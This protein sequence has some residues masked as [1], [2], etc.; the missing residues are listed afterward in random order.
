M[1]EQ[2]KNDTLPENAETCQAAED[3]TQ[4]SAEVTFDTIRKKFHHIFDAID[5]VDAFVSRQRGR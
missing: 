3:N 2:Q 1:P 5:D 4:A